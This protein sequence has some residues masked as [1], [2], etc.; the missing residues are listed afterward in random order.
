MLTEQPTVSDLAARAHEP[1]WMEVLFEL[2]H[3]RCIIEQ[4]KNRKVNHSREYTVHTK[5]S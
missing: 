3:T 5:T 1:G 2:G 4:F